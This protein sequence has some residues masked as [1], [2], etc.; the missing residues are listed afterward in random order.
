MLFGYRE[1]PNGRRS[2]RRRKIAAASSTAESRDARA[3]V[4]VPPGG[5]DRRGSEDGGRSRRR[6]G[7][8]EPPRGGAAS[9]RSSGSDRVDPDRW[10]AANASGPRRDE[11]WSAPSRQIHGCVLWVEGALD[12]KA[13]A[14]R[15][16]PL[17]TT[18]FITCRSHR[19]LL[20]VAGRMPRHRVVG[21]DVGGAS[22]ALGSSVPVVRSRRRRLV[23]P[24]S[25][26]PWSSRNGGYSS[27]IRAT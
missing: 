21:P 20:L 7:W 5:R 25:V 17:S 4:P 6:Q 14:A 1:L 15:M 23:G 12:A 18:E 2:V 9:R 3:A 13:I 16:I 19:E 22:T 27:R 24:G 8:P 10:P 11:G 26:A